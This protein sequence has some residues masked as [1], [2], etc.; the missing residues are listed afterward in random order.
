[1]ARAATFGLAVLA[2]TIA[3]S[4]SSSAH[5]E[6]DDVFGLCMAGCATDRTAARCTQQCDGAKTRCSLSGGFAM[7]GA[8]FLLLPNDI[9][10]DQSVKR[11]LHEHPTPIKRNAQ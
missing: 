9:R 7:E 3:F 1:M 10:L 11:E 5:I 8:G 4:K 2:L 6:C